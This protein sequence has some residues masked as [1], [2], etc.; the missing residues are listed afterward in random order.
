MDFQGHG[1]IINYLNEEVNREE[2]EEAETMRG[3]PIL[4]SDSEPSGLL[5]KVS[6]ANELH[7]LGS[8]ALQQGQTVLDSTLANHEAT[9]VEAKETALTRVMAQT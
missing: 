9:E 6:S 5:R 8:S 1:A 4:A 2:A 7:E 3:G